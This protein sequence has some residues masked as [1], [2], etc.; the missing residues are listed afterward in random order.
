MEKV[1]DASL[2]TTSVNMRPHPQADFYAN[3][4]P[5]L[6]PISQEAQGEASYRGASLPPI[7]KEARA[8]V[9]TSEDDDYSTDDADESDTDEESDNDNGEIGWGGDHGSHSVHPGTQSF[10]NHIRH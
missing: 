2:K 10:T 4:D 8:E 5:S 9:S 3:I 1:L 6:R 7:G